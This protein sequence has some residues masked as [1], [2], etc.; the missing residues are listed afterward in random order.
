MA[1]SMATRIQTVPPRNLWF[2]LSAAAAAWLILG[3]IDLMIVWQVCGY[4]EQYGADKVH[5]FA[6]I[7]A[8]VISVVLFLVVVAAGLISHRN[9]RALSPDK[10][11]FETRATD[12]REFMATVGMIISITLGAGIVWLSIPPLMIQ[13]CVRAK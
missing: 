10:G 1:S 12:R 9:L 4:A 3:F 5:T 6:R 11:L 7:A 2:G 8:F 13:L